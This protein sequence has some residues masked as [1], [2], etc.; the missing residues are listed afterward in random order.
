M[1]TKKNNQ[2]ELFDISLEEMK[3]LALIKEMRM[4]MRN[5]SQLKYELIELKDTLVNFLKSIPFHDEQI[6][7]D[8]A[9]PKDHKFHEILET[10]HL[11]DNEDGPNE[12]D[13]VH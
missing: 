12:N 8:Y 3:F 2:L 4:M 11:L 9:G 7:N 10:R 5:F 1:Q 13:T 6:V